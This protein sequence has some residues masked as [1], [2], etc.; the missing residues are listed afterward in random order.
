M[1]PAQETAELL[2][3]LFNKY[4]STLDQLRTHVEHGM[5]S[6]LDIDGIVLG[7]VQDLLM[8][9]EATVVGAGYIGGP[10]APTAPGASSAQAMHF[11]WW[12]GPLAENPLLGTTTEVTR[13]D[14]ASREYAD[15]LRD[16]SS[17]EWYSVPEST[18]SRHI[19]G[20][21]VDHLCTCDYMLTLTTPVVTGR[22]GIVGLDVL[23]RRIEPEVLRILRTIPEPAALVTSTGRIVVSTADDWD[24]GARLKGPTG[25][26]V[27]GT[28]FLVTTAES[29]HST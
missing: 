23:V 27:P 6:G 22:L 7:F 18:G 2:G 16:F 5:E 25:Q 11:A 20:P 28:P 8:A 24:L 4:F 3:I 14:L 26:P 15:Y 19:T 9:E 13:L 17:L 1:N 10:E 21:Y 12:L 29:N